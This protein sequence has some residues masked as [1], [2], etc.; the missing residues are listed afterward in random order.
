MSELRSL[1]VYCC[2]SLLLSKHILGFI[3]F[4]LFST[5][6]LSITLSICLQLSWCL[7]ICLSVY[8][9]ICLFLRLYVYKCLYMPISLW[10]SLF[11]L[12]CLNLFCSRIEWQLCLPCKLVV[13]L[14]LALTPLLFLPYSIS[15]ILLFHFL[16]LQI[17]FFLT[18]F[19]TLL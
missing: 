15:S 8:K 13:F 11:F 7:F 2:M 16:S 3:F 6:L 14:S 9:C 5:V 4:C 18:F 12:I 17:S 19:S 10:A 1:D